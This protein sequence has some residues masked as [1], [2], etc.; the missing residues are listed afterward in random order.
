MNP[1]ISQATSPTSEP[2]TWRSIVRAGYR[3]GIIGGI[4][5]STIGGL[6]GL[7]FY[8]Q[9]RP[10]LLADGMLI[11]STLVGLECGFILGAIVG[12][13]RQIRKG[14]HRFAC[15]RCG[16]R[17][18]VRKGTEPTN[19]CPVCVLQARL[20]ALT[21][22]QREALYKLARSGSPADL[23][24]GAQLI[25]GIPAEDRAMRSSELMTVLAR[26]V[27]E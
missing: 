16:Q 7:I 13:K 17:V 21:A 9:L 18:V 3:G 14:Y 10:E 15:S 23:L 8:L 19:L 25:L 4:P 11:G 26:L 27:D 6:F 2:V 24:T 1:C 12:V 22:D 20:N 5:G